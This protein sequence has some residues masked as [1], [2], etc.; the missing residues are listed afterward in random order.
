MALLK[1]C[2]DTVV[3]VLPAEKQTFRDGTLFEILDF[4]KVC[5]LLMY[6][7]RLASKDPQKVVRDSNSV[8]AFLQRA[9]RALKDAGMC[10]RVCVCFR[11]V[12]F[13]AIFSLVSLHR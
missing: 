10:V 4:S 5:E 8:L 3:R 11:G 2:P 6:T 9:L 13:L 12:F 7:Y 1:H